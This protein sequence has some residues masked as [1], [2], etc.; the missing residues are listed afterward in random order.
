[1]VNRKVF[2]QNS[3]IGLY[4]IGA[5]KKLQGARKIAALLKNAVKSTGDAGRG[6]AASTGQACT[7]LAGLG[8]RFF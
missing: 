8:G 1:L 7:K 4:L 3:L 2:E 6:G 5:R